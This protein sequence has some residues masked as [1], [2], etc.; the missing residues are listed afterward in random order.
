MRYGLSITKKDDET[1][2]ECALRYASKHGMAEEVSASY[3]R[4]L[5]DGLD[6][7]DAALAACMDWDIAELVEE[8]DEEC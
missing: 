6:E 3:K 4:A 5:S 8:P 1:W 2:E 7:G